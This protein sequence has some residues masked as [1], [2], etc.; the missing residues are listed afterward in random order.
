MPRGLR[1]SGEMLPETP[2]VPEASLQGWGEIEFAIR[3]LS[4]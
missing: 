4:G 3:A 2:I 1:R